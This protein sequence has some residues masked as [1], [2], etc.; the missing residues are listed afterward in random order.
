MVKKSNEISLT[1]GNFDGV[2]LGHQKI[3]KELKAQKCL[4]TFSNHPGKILHHRTVPLL[5][6]PSQKLHLIKQAGVD[7]MVIVPFTRELSLQSA[8]TFLSSLKQRIPFTHLVL[9]HD[10]AVGHLRQGD[11]QEIDVLGK[12]LDFTSQF[13]GPLKIDEKVISSTWIRELVQKGD[14][15]KASL[16][17]G[18][19]Y[20]IYGPVLPGAGKGK[21]LGFQ[22]AN[23]SV[24]TLCLPPLGVYAVEVIHNGKPYLGVANLGSAPT[25]HINRTT[26]LEVHI[27]EMK[28]S[29]YEQEIEVIF[30]RFLRPEREFSSPESLKKQISQDIAQL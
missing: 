27:L 2:H 15:D 6:T 29:L 9:G 7:Q 13:L 30:K 26:L 3:L 14:L 20:S 8:E 1:V 16:L 28:G 24:E 12:K 21:L 10:A 4:F 11:R 19:P 18:R 17:L 22:T 23:L 5:T 25:L